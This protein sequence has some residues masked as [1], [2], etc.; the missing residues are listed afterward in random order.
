MFSVIMPVYNGEKFIDDA[1]KSVCAQTYDNW[2]LIIVNDGSKDNTADVLKKYESNS[3]IKI[4]HKENGGV[5]VARNTAISA[6]KGEYIVFLDADDV[7]HTNHLEVMNELI[8]EYPDAGLY[9]T[10]TRT[11]LVNG[12]IIEECN[13]FKDKPDVVYLEDFFKAYYNDKSAMIFNITTACFSRKAL[14][15]TG[16]FPVGCAIGEDLELSLR[17]AAYFPVVLSKKATGT[18]K[19]TNST[20]TKDIS[21]DPDWK[22]FD[23]VNNLYSDSRIGSDKKENLKKIMQWFTMRKARHLVICGRR[24]EAFSAYR[25]IGNDPKLLKDK[26]ITLAILLMPVFMVRK[27]FEVRWRGRA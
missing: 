5:S 7:W 27:L 15:V 10:F 1:V 18:Y 13:F 22:F 17:V 26:L 19:K 9:A 3:Q 20:A 23:T 2:E 4:I 8:T 11:E 14:D 12:G 21:F 16:L 6:S 24:K 25:D